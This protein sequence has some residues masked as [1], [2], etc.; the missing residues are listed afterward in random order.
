MGFT[1]L[2]NPPVYREL[3]RKVRLPQGGFTLVELLV[4]I[5]IIGILIAL[6]LPALGSVR[7]AAQ[8]ASCANHLRQ[9]GLATQT[10]VEK[11]SAY[12]AGGWGYQWV[13]SPERGS[14]SAQPGGWIYNLLPFIGEEAIHRMGH[15]LPEDER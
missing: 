13:G 3:P 8:R 4:V 9:I 14:G 7:E 12:P 11:F 10:H 2:H 1:P 5:A 15:G 6:L